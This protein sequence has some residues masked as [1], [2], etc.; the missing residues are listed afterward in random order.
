MTDSVSPLWII[1]DQ[2]KAMARDGL[3]VLSYYFKDNTIIIHVG[4]ESQAPVVMQRFAA[5]CVKKLAG[6]RVSVRNANNQEVFHYILQ[7]LRL[8]FFRT[9]LTLSFR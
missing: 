5:T 6:Y 9:A 3:H 1:M 2:V 8:S 4:V 7:L